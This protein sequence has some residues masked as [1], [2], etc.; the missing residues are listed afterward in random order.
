MVEERPDCL[1]SMRLLR[2]RPW[3]HPYPMQTSAEAEVLRLDDAWNEAYR[4]H[5]RASLQGIL[6]EDFTALSSTGEPIS[7]ALLMINPLETAE[8]VHFSEQDVHV[9]GET[10]ITRGRLRLDLGDRWVDQRFVRVFARRNQV[11]QAVS[12]AVTPQA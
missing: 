4:Q 8:S 6:A 12:V 5:D 10:A 9:F 7:K 11:W 1:L 3:W 2:T